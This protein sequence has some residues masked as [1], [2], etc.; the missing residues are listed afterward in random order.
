MNF[1]N[2]HLTFYNFD[3]EHNDKP[4][5]YSLGSNE[6]VYMNLDLAPKVGQTNKSNLQFRVIL[7]GAPS[8]EVIGMIHKQKRL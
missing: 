5:I 7:L 3:S 1:H 6:M 4:M 2:S 8:H